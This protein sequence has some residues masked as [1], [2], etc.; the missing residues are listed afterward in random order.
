MVIRVPNPPV[1]IL[2]KPVYHS[3]GDIYRHI[4]ADD[5]QLEGA[6]RSCGIPTLVAKSLAVPSGKIPSAILPPR[7]TSAVATINGAIA[8]AGD[9]RFNVQLQGFIDKPSGI[10]LFRV[11]RT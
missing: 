5:R 8:T 9:H 1:A 11:T 6:A 4:A 10:A 2:I 7:S 3:P